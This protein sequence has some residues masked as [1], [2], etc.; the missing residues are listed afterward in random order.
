MN[1]ANYTKLQARAVKLQAELNDI[2]KQMEEFRLAT[3]R[4][5]GMKR[6]NSSTTLTFNGRTLNVTRDLFGYT[7]V[8]EKGKFI[9]KDYFG[10]IHDVRFAVAIGEI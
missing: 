3:L 2:N 10:N 9:A 7:Q 6:N 5:V 8:K 4:Q 1:Y